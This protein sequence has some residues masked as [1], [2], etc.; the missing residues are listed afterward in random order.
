V[1]DR[2]RVHG[3]DQA[4]GVLDDQPGVVAGD[5]E[6]LVAGHTEPFSSCGGLVVL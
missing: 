3:A 5:G 4:K 1:L 6:E 2:L